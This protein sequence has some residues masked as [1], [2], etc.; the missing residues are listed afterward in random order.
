MIAPVGNNADVTNDWFLVE[1]PDPPF[2]SEGERLLGPFY[3]ARVLDTQ[4]SDYLP[5][6]RGAMLLTGRSS[7]RRAVKY[8]IDRYKRRHPD[9]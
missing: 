3:Q 7:V 2:K 8:R 9:L 5:L 4:T 6:A 1:Q